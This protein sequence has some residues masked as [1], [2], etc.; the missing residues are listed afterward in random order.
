MWVFIALAVATQTVLCKEVTPDQN[1]TCTRSAVVVKTHEYS[2]DITL[3]DD[4]KAA[5][6]EI[7]KAFEAKPQKNPFP[8]GE[9]ASDFKLKLETMAVR[10]DDAAAMIVKRLTGFN[11]NGVIRA[12]VEYSASGKDKRQYTVLEPG[13]FNDLQKS[14]TEK[15]VQKMFGTYGQYPNFGA[16][17]P[18]GNPNV[19]QQYGA[20][21]PNY[22]SYQP[23][24]PWGNN[25]GSPYPNTYPNTY[26]NA[27]PNMMGQPNNMY[28]Q[29]GTPWMNQ[30]YSHPQYGYPPSYGNHN[31]YAPSNPH[32]NNN[33]GP[34][35]YPQNNPPGTNFGN[36]Q[37]YR[38][39]QYP[40]NLGNQQG[41]KPNQYAPNSGNQQGY[42]PNQHAP[43]SGNQQGYRPNNAPNS[44]NQQGYRPNQYPP[45]SG[46]QQGYRPNQHAPN[47]GNQQG[48]KP[49][50][51]APNS[52]NQQGNKPNQYT[53]NVQNRGG[54][55]KSVSSKVPQSAQKN[56]RGFPKS[57]YYP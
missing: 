7:S 49:N 43:N 17:P 47:S 44:G 36:Q 8:G 9:A 50:Q 56:T 11:E 33:F 57:M 14:C 15:R 37:G 25:Y 5:V 28:P 16:S 45:N 46:N 38:P 41:Y 23:Y 4:H 54:N 53:P 2:K 40:P 39:D 55:N 3:I 48:Y 31:P 20:P 42:K 13:S 27:Y 18:A 26:P 29:M 24:G 12:T 22:Y 21:V 32:Y 1:K 30:G 52:R 35:F 6:Q 51:Y 19:Y 34:G 10:K